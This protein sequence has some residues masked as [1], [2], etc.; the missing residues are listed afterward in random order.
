MAKQKPAANVAP[1]SEEKATDNKSDATV[2]FG[3]DPFNGEVYCFFD[4]EGY[5]LENWRTEHYSEYLT[6][7]EGNLITDE[8]TAIACHEKECANAHFNCPIFA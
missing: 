8:K 1:H 7:A 5:W 4:G 2:A 3:Y 6:D